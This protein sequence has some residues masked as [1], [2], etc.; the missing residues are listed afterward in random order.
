M[1]EEEKDNNNNKNKNVR[2]TKLL[3]LKQT[4]KTRKTAKLYAGIMVLRKDTNLSAYC[5]RIRRVNC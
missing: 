4:M 5:C 2:P 3:I 1:E